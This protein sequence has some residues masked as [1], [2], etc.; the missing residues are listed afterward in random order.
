MRMQKQPSVD[1]AYMLKNYPEQN[2]VLLKNHTY[3][4]GVHLQIGYYVFMSGRLV[5]LPI[6]L[7]GHT[8]EIRQKQ[9]E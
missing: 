3:Q 5:F 2:P 9:A 4:V 6:D 8:Y 1:M 7:C